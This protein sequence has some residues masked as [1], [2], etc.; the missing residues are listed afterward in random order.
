MGRCGVDNALLSAMRF[1]FVP[2]VALAS[3]VLAFHPNQQ[4]RRPCFALNMIA[5]GF[6]PPKPPGKRTKAAKVPVAQAIAQK[7]P[8][9][10][11]PVAAGELPDDAF[12][13]FPPLPRDEQDTLRKADGDGTGFPPEA[14][15]TN[16]NMD[17]LCN[18]RNLNTYLYNVI[19]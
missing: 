3:G 14:S 8:A 10:K 19:Q 1:S 5:R 9:L 17:H 12:S 11:P 18:I 7:P 2:C 16:C 6:G 13:Q 15:S 4:T